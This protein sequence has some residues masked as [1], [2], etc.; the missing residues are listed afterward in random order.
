[1]AVIVFFLRGCNLTT[2]LDA[3]YIQTFQVTD[4][5]PNPGSITTV[6]NNALVFA[7]GM[8]KG[9]DTNVTAPSG[10]SNLIIEN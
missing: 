9:T 8:G 7:C 2:F 6:T 10:Y 3:A 1:M 4:T 5:N